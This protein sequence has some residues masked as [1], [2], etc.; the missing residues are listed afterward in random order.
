MD[1]LCLLFEPVTVLQCF[2][3]SK[4]CYM[5]VFSS[6]QADWTPVMAAKSVFLFQCDHA[7]PEASMAA[8]LAYTCLQDDWSSSNEQLQI[9]RDAARASMDHI[10]PEEWVDRFGNEPRKGADILVQ[11][12]ERE[13]AYRCSLLSLMS[14]RCSAL[15]WPSGAGCYARGLTS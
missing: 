5:S 12:L 9:A 11:C 6:L 4:A 14:A 13:G 1:L 15:S 8:M 2:T 3:L 7:S 10:G